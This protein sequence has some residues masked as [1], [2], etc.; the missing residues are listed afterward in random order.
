[1]EERVA[2]LAERVA[3]LEV[4]PAVSCTVRALTPPATAPICALEQGVELKQA[5]GLGAARAADGPIVLVG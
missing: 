2:M 1:M 4:A 3:A 5:G